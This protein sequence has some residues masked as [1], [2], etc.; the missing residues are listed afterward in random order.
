MPRKAFLRAITLILSLA[1]CTLLDESPSDG[2]NGNTGSNGNL[3]V[4][5]SATPTNGPAPLQVRFESSNATSA[6]PNAL[7]HTWQL[8]NRTF[9]GG[10]NRSHTFTREGTFDVSV[11][12]SDGQVTV[13]DVVTI[14]VGE[15]SGAEPGNG[16]PSIIVDASPTSGVEDLTVAHGR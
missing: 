14:Q 9:M 6:S 7:D 12:V 4:N 5:L 11:T 1:S 8:A 16:S 15:G 13:D 10:T 3:S 2:S